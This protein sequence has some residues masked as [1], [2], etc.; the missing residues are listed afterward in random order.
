MK[1]II[2][3]YKKATTLVCLILTLVLIAAA[4]IVKGDSPADIRSWRNIEG[5]IYVDD[6]M[7]AAAKAGKLLPIYSVETDGNKIAL[8]FDN[9][10]GADD[11]PDILRALD[12]YQ[13]KA[14][15]FVLGCW[16]EKYP[17]VVR[18]IY[19]RG[20]EIANHSYAH[21]KPSK[22]DKAGLIKEI[23]KCNAAIKRVT[24]EDCKIYRPPYGDYND[25]VISTALEMGMY[26]IQ[27]DVD[28]LDWKPETTEAEILRRVTE[29]T[30]PGSILLFHNDTKY[31]AKILPEVIKQ[32]LE[33]GYEF[34]KVSELIYK[35]NYYIDHTGRQ[36]KK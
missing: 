8:T 27:W 32:L 19:E 26:P 16:V 28:S 15:F 13:V 20:H 9:A 34:V 23:E 25:L 21:Y 31:T 18:E 7:E 10:W 5:E 3:D 1:F 2:I 24:G 29:K 22:L 12:K 33:Q 6:Y 30:R 35:D 14:T 11:I 36:F 17:D 4:F